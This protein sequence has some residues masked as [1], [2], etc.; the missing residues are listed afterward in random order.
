MTFS[1][2]LSSDADAPG[3]SS[4]L[5]VKIRL[6]KVS[7]FSAPRTV[8]GAGWPES[9]T[10]KCIGI[11]SIYGRAFSPPLQVLLCPHG[12]VIMAG[13]EPKRL[14]S[15]RGGQGSS[16]H[17]RTQ[18]DGVE[19]PWISIG[20]LSQVQGSLLAP[21]RLIVLMKKSSAL[22]WGEEWAFF[23]FLASQV[24]L[25]IKKCLPRQETRDLGLTPRSG[26]SPGGVHGN[27]LQYSCLGNSMD[28]GAWW[29]TKSQTGL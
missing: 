5:W 25:G 12:G 20:R 23:F 6:I 3:P 15:L 28:R 14:R 16:P 17:W 18:E 2:K 22:K 26:G 10:L 7:S 1:N 11:S 9:E 4:R 13:M 21:H 29:A 27:P 24:V 8:A 19:F